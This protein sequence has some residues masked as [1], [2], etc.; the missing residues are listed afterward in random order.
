MK[1]SIGL[2][3]LL[4]CACAASLRAD[5]VPVVLAPAP[6]DGAPEGAGKELK[7]L[8]QRQRDLMAAAQKET[9]QA[10]LET[11]HEK[12]Q[13][14]C[15]D[16][17]NFLNEY[18]NLAAGYVSYALFLSSP[19]V[20]EPGRAVALLMKA[21][22]LNPNLALVK[23]QLGNY[24]VQQDR[25]LDALNYY[26][27]AVQLEPREPLYRYQI[28]ML[29]MLKQDALLKS[30]Q[31]TRA[32]LD[33]DMQA[34]LA[35]AKE[36]APGNIRYAYAYCESF[37]KLG[38]PDWPA[39]LASWRDMEA[40]V[41]DTLGRQTIRLQ[42]AD[43]LARQGKADE[44]RA[45]LAAINEPA[46]QAQKQNALDLLAPNPPLTPPAAIA[47]PTKA[48]TSGAAKAPTSSSL[49]SV[50]FPSAPATTPATVQ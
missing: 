34:A 27:S 19:V 43:V 50:V 36:L 14:L 47:L 4:A 31:W 35:K 10:G 23:N 28:G 15:D 42:E 49:P 11:L 37:Y 12:F 32:A 2:F 13:D 46:L 7:A 30:A 9:S 8:V 26:L 1:F 5:D 21:N 16:Y 18:P 48:P 44:A 25:P 38:A 20:G 6:T 33:K 39:A 45:L 22:E 24:L 17:E 40:R 29:I 3:L 41:P